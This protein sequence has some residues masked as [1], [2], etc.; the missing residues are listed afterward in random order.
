MTKK[1]GKRQIVFL[2]LVAALC[3]AVYV[4][5]YF[6]KPAS[7]IKTGPE[8][9]TSQE[10]NL[11]QAQYVNAQG[12]EDYFASAELKRSKAHAEALAALNAVLEDDKA[13]EASKKAA[14]TALETM[15]KNI[16]AEAEI[17]N[18]I[19]AKTGNKAIVSLGETAE[20]VLAKGTLNDNS[21][22]QIKEIIV[23]K[24]EISAEKIT[25]VEVK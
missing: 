5:W 15:S 25:L 17:E 4:N 10:A 23:N 21:A 6:T 19:S 14:Q 12:N 18:L 24:A 1:I 9:E 3:A 7:E 16:K 13:D 20:V 8:V 2:G 22:I 11:G